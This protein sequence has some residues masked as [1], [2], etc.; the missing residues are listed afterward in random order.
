VRPAIGIRFSQ[1]FKG[2]YLNCTRLGRFQREQRQER[3]GKSR[4]Y[5]APTRLRRTNPTL[6]VRIS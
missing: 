6:S 2:L 5:M 4:T 3:D 1:D